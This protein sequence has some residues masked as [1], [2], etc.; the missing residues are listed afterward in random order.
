MEFIR[1]KNGG[2]RRSAQAHL[3]ERMAAHSAHVRKY[4]HVVGSVASLAIFVLA[5]W[6][7][8]RALG[9]YE[10][11]DIAARLRE[12]PWS[13]VVLAAV[14]AGCSYLALG[15]FDW[16]ATRYIGRKVAT[17]RVLLASFVSHSISH[18]AGFAALT[19]GAIRYRMYSAAG[20]SA[21]EVGA[22]ILFCGATFIL[23][24]ST[25]AA[26]ALLV[27]PSKFAALTS[28]PEQGLRLTGAAVLGLVGIYLGL[29]KVVRRPVHVLGRALKL[30]NLRIALLQIAVAA[31]DLAFAAATL[32][33]LLPAGAPPLW[34]VVG[35]YVLANLAGLVAHVPGGLGVFESAIVLMLPELA[36]DATLGALVLFRVVYNLAPLALGGLALAAYEVLMRRR[37]AGRTARILLRELE[38]AALALLTFSVGGMLVITGAVPDA[39]ERLAFMAE[40]LPV[41][42][43]EGA[44]ILGS[45]AGAGLLLSARGIFRRLKG[46]YSAALL[47]L[48]LGGAA[49][50]MRG[51]D[52]E[53]AVVCGLLMLILVSARGSFYRL[54]SVAGL[55]Y[56]PGWVGASCI[57]L[58]TAAWL[59]AIAFRR[60][61]IAIEPS[62]LFG[63]D[64]AGR[65]L[66]GEVGAVA[67]YL[68]GLAMSLRRPRVVPRLPPAAE[69]E[70]AAVIVAAA[71]APAANRALLGGHSL[72][73]D[74]ARRA[75]VMYR[76]EDGLWVALGEPVGPEDAWLDL[77]WRFC[78]AS[79]AAGAQPVFL[80]V[81]LRPLYL[82]L[83][84]SFSRIGEVG[85]VALDEVTLADPRYGMLRQAHEASDL[86]F[87]VLPPGAAP[88]V[89]PTGRFDVAV[90]M[91]GGTRQ[92]AAALW[93][94]RTVLALDRVQSDGAL[95]DFLTVETMLWGQ[96]NGFREFELPPLAADSTDR[97]LQRLGELAGRPWSTDVGLREKYPAHWLPLFAAVPPKLAL[98]PA[99]SVLAKVA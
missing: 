90:A 45:A 76:A 93:R 61:G 83:G 74:A 57:M 8:H 60:H 13:A 82:D 84:L 24:A 25:L 87:A 37:A 4:W 77:A 30:P 21:L 28:I 63:D 78:E 33:V 14:A 71:A 40:R 58:I 85:R 6:L 55:G 59:T 68:A 72:M 9:M 34:A 97:W 27:E 54:Q 20:L 67:V 29:C 95:Q 41:A 18:S 3:S 56:S 36:A 50:V 15:G 94:S 88:E 42:A 99:E 1:R 49:A 5:L 70:Q 66:R 79:I 23:G 62:A 52:V 96:R 89:E 81:P 17:S 53:E 98:A 11:A 64:G 51:L 73:F 39:P 65:A 7:L 92:A 80:Q 91:R 10:F 22:V 38:P 2:E 69:V 26:I 43:M 46:A 31:I 75:F 48:A 47:L 12:T 16:L 35:I 44:Q 86:G 19:G 32:F